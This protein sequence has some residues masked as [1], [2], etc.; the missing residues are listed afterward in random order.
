MAAQTTHLLGIFY[1]CSYFFSCFAPNNL[2]SS[3]VEIKQ[4]TYIYIYISKHGMAAVSLPLYAHKQDDRSLATV[5]LGIFFFF[6]LL[7]H[8][9]TA[10]L[11][12]L[13]L[14]NFSW[15]RISKNFEL[16]DKRLQVQNHIQS[17]FP[18]LYLPF[19]PFFFFFSP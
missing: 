15:L 13:I 17:T 9:T 16:W 7:G 6:F 2:V 18:A 4:S 11:F 5:P 12:L 1:A 10:Y 3:S 19:S 8:Q 14:L